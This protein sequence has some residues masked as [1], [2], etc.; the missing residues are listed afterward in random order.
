MC[1]VCNLRSSSVSPKAYART[2]MRE[3]RSAIAL[4]RTFNRSKEIAGCTAIVCVTSLSADGVP[5]FVTS[6]S[7]YR[8]ARF[9][10]AE[11][12]AFD[13]FRM[14]ALAELRAEVES[15]RQ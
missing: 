7:P 3:E 9:T 13:A 10:T 6:W 12:A 4:G 15:A 11:F 5:H 8:P 1:S 2:R 14:Q